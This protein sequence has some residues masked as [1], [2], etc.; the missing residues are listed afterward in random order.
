[1]IDWK[2][3]RIQEKIDGSLLK[4]WYYFETCQ[5]ILST[6]GTIDASDAKSPFSLNGINSFNDIF[7]TATKKTHQE[8]VDYYHL[9]QNKT[10]MFEITGPH[11]KVVIQYPLDLYQ[12]GVRNNQTYVEERCD[13]PIKNRRT[14]SFH[15]LRKLLHLQRRYLHRKKGSLLLMMFGIE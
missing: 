13:L 3:A 14:L 10:Y 15:H 2:T 5:W 9:D 11:N 8:F 4:I 1:M 12:I 7:M 6:N